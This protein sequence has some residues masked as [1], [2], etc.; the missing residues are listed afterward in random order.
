M[1]LKFVKPEI[2][3]IYSEIKDIEDWKPENPTEVDFFVT[4][5]IGIEGKKGSDDFTLHIV[6]SNIVSQLQDKRKLFVISYYDQ[7]DTI[8]KKVNEIVFKENH[9]NWQSICERLSTYFHWEYEDYKD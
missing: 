6:T 2:K 5:S 3:G 4:F 7:W 8:L 1:K 9:T